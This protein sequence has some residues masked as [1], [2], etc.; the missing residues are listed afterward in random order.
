MRLQEITELTHT[1]SG[2]QL[3]KSWFFDSQCLGD[4]PACFRMICTFFDSF[5]GVEVYRVDRFPFAF[6]FKVHLIV[7]V[8]C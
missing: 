2:C 4:P 1:D 8:H 7:V 6:D 3:L 5:G